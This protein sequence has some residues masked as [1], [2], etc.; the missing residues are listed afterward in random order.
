MRLIADVDTGIDDALALVLLA[1]RPDV[2]LVGV[3]TTTGNTT[4]A[5]AARNSAAVLALAESG[6]AS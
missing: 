6:S 1:A 2:D 4:A 5:R 3:S